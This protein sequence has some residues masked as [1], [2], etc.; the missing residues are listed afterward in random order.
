MMHMCVGNLTIMGSDNG[1]L[2]GWYQVIIWTSAGIL[3]IGPSGIRFSDI[4]IEIQSF[5]IEQNAIRNVVYK[6]ATIL[7]RP[8]CVKQLGLT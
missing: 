6:M 2:P 8:Q 7:S 1:L 5:F 4:V 3:L